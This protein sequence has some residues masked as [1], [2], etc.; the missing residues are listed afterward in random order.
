[1]KAWTKINWLLFNCQLQRPLYLRPFN[2]NSKSKV[3]D[4][5]FYLLFDL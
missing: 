4:L 1:M 2:D 5:S 3:R